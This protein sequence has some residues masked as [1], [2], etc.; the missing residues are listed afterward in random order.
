M[1]A[2]G[3]L[4]LKE[5]SHNE[6]LENINC[7]V[8]RHLCDLGDLGCVGWK[9]H[10]PRFLWRFVYRLAFGRSVCWREGLRSIWSGYDQQSWRRLASQIVWGRR[11]GCQNQDGCWPE[12]RQHH[13][14][15]AG[16]RWR[17][18]LLSSILSGI[19]LLNQVAP[20]SS[21]DRKVPRANCTGLFFYLKFF[22]CS[23][24]QKLTAVSFCVRAI[25]FYILN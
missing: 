18:F 3:S 12:W 16:H 24:T 10:H 8:G 20:C 14:H 23:L 15:Y 5:F 7:R 13:L 11:Y 25:N 21:P 2:F 6:Y 19:G 1:C 22:K 4:S 17:G 9:W